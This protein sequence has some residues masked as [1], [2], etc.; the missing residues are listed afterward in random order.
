[1]RGPTSFPQVFRRSRLLVLAFACLLALTA[2]SFAAASPT[3]PASLGAVPGKLHLRKPAL[4][5]LPGATARPRFACPE[6]ACDAIVVPQSAL[7][8]KADLGSGERRGLDPQDLQSAYRI[9]STLPAAQTVAIVD[10]YG[11]PNAESDL[12]AYRERYGLPACTKASGCFKKVNEKGES[13]N[14]PA[15]EPEWDVEAALDEDMVSAACPQC[16]ILLVEGTTEE[17]ADLGASVNEAVKLGAN[18]VSNSY[19][20]PQ[21]YEPWCGTTDCTQY[22]SDYVHSG[23][24]IT[25]SAGD[26]GYDDVYEGFYATDFPAASPNVTAVGGTAL[27][28]VASAPRGWFEEV[29]NE[30]AISAGTG[31]GC[32]LSETKPTWQTDKGCATRTDNDVAAVAAVISPVSIRI[33]GIWD[34]V[35]GTSVSSPLVAGIEAHAISTERS[36]GAHAFY[37]DPGSLFDVTEGFSWDSYNESGTSECAAAEYLCNAEV[38]YD[39][40]TGMGTPNGVPVP[41]PTVTKVEP[42][43]GPTTGA[44]TVTITGTNFTGA[45]EVKFGPTAAK[46]F[47]VVSATSITAESPAHSAG[48]VNVTVTTT[49]GK[50]ATGSADDFTYV[51]P[52]TVTKV[53]PHEGPTTGS[54]KVTITGTNF[55]GAKEVKFG[56]VAAKSFTVA[57]AT[58]ITAESPVGSVGTVNV[59]VTTA[60]GKS[61]TSSADDFT[62]VAAP[63]TVTTVEPST[64][65]GQAPIEAEPAPGV[66]ALGSIVFSP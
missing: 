64:G 41:P 4:G 40:P 52:P 43:E 1:M 12:A 2:P 37:K 47:K 65:P 51:A 7:P 54:T 34:L 26:S 27:F 10:A 66:P 23:V 21:D 15:E 60:G 45:S 58:S 38:G 30:P 33:D 11:Y 28:K 17:P 49:G 29:W 25:A 16:H 55:T 19:G 18:E 31:G 36:L 53:E 22:N 56:T 8:L 42:H 61:A 46:S 13:K 44:T 50:S 32:T 59:T 3:A 5:V 14:Y 57:T 9:P 48:T 39:G 35:G 24:V 63:T 62:Y 20:Y 6:G